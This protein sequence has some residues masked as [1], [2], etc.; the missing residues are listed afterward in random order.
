MENKIS[1]AIMLSAGLGTRLRDITKGEIPKVMVLLV[2]KPLL[3]WHIE[4]FKKC[5]VNEFFINLHYLH[6]KITEY[7]GDGSKWGVKIRYFLETP[8]ILGTAGGIKDFESQFNENF[9]VIYADTFYQ[10]NYKRIAEFYFSLENPI[11]LTTARITDHPEDSDLAIVGEKNEIKEFMIKPHKKLPS[12][13]F[14]GT[15]APYIFSKKILEYIPENKYY[16]I[17]HNLVPDLLSKGLNYYVYKLQEGEFRK[18][19]GTADRY[20]FVENYLKKKTAA[21]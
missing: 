5:G 2:G 10:I 4:Q 7:F 21:S 15:S 1:Q 11:G 16:E 9:F 20:H 17:D 3:E 18:D 14:Y 13:D 12:K 19:I 8:E 6:E